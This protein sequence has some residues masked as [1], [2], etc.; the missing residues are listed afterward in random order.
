[1][2]TELAELLRGTINTELPHLRSVKENEAG[3]KTSI[4]WSRKEELGLLIDSASHNHL[5]FV[6]AVLAP[7]FHGLPYDQNGSV[8]IHGYQE[9]PWSD[10]LEFWQSYNLL[11]AQMI[12]RIPEAKLLTL[13]HIGD[14]APVTLHFLIEDYVAHMQHHLDHILRRDRVTQYPRP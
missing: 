10:L 6:G 4:A 14:G 7:E 8:M 1:M 9:L 11:L 5:R 3:V 12:A 2:P 13:C